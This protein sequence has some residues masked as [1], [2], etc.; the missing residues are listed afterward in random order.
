[1][2]EAVKKVTEACALGDSDF[3]D[4][5]GF[6]SKMLPY[7]ILKTFPFARI[8]RRKESIFVKSSDFCNQIS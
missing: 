8:L 4:L 2:E 1:M 3:N 7:T 6:T 5:I